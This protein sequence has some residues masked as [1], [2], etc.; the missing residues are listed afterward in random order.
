VPLKTRRW[1]DPREPD[2]GLRVL[3][4]RYRPR[5]VSK[6]AET[7][8]QWWPELGPSRALHA[9]FYGKGEGESS[10]GAGGLPFAQYLP[11]YHEEMQSQVFRI[12][13]LADLVASGETVTLLCSSACIDPAICHRTILQGLIEAR[14][15]GTV[16]KSLPNRRPAP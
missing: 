2:D 5:G 7:W 12:R 9:A 8:D 4:S 1:N 3:I 14:V 16:G 13:A 15:S 6:A 11:R 10:A